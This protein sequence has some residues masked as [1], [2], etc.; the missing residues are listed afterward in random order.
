MAFHS[1]SSF[2]ACLSLDIWKL[3]GWRCGALPIAADRPFGA[4]LLKNHR[5]TVTAFDYSNR[6][7]LDQV[8]GIARSLTQYLAGNGRWDDF[9]I[10][11]GKNMLKNILGKHTKYGK[12]E[13][14]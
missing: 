5:N 14:L 12:C 10:G 1:R 4:T 9:S 2:C 6:G 13:L 11:D 8:G 7:L 3:W